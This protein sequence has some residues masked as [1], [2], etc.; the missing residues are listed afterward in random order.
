[1]H[2][3]VPVDSLPLEEGV[4]LGTSSFLV[5]GSLLVIGGVCGCFGACLLSW[6][7]RR[8]PGPTPSDAVWRNWERATARALF[9][10]R[11][12]RRVALAFQNY[13]NH[14][15]R[16]EGPSRPATARAEAQVEDL[17]TP[18]REGPAIRRRRHGSHSR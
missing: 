16:R 2:H 11:R 12:R 17:P 8:G 6:A 13:S 4:P 18:L 14:Q 9:F 10:L 1:M 15:L 3:L 5:V 7:C